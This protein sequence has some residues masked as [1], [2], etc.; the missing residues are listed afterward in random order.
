MTFCFGIAPLVSNKAIVAPC[1]LFYTTKIISFLSWSIAW[2]C[3]FRL[4]FMTFN[5]LSYIVSNSR[6][7][8]D[9][10]NLCF[11]GFTAFLDEA[12]PPWWQFCYGNEVV[13][14]LPKLY[15]EQWPWIVHKYVKVHYR[16]F[17]GRWVQNFSATNRTDSTSQFADGSDICISRLQGHFLQ[18]EYAPIGSTSNVSCFRLHQS[19]SKLA[20]LRRVLARSFSH[21]YCFSERGPLILII[22]FYQIFT[23]RA[24]VSRI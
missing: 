6:T 11:M 20:I 23:R 9:F 5:C 13:F 8:F 22:W 21:C 12:I 4:I 1:L 16:K 14:F 18:N 7:L 2:E 24:I 17:G 3:P 10:T 19:I 15:L